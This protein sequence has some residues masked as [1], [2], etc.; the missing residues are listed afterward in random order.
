MFRSAVIAVLALAVSSSVSAQSV[1]L[2]SQALLALIKQPVIEATS[3]VPV[4]FVVEVRPDLPTK[5]DHAPRWATAISIAGP[6]VDGLS[7]VYALRQSGPARH[8]QE[9]NGLYQRLFGADVKPGEILGFKI[10]QAVVMGLA[11]HFAPKDK[12]A[13]VLFN[14]I[15]AGALQSF[16]TT[17]NIRE[18]VRA[19][20]AN[21]AGSPTP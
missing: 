19:R 11:T 10:G 3:L 2:E 1:V 21:R 18:G 17:M 20:R 9:G 12:R 4:A 7:T 16:A 13:Q 15:A 8:V 5:P 14:V 6:L